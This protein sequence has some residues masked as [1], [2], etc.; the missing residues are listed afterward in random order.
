MEYPVSNNH[1][2]SRFECLMED[3]RS[4]YLDYNEIEEGLNFAH[5][6]VPKS[7]EGKG[8]AAALVKFGLEYAKSNG[9]L[10]QPSCPYVTAYIKRHPEYLS[11][12]K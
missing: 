2:A 11:L 5:T 10:I 4:A 1:E 9:M 6:Y 12:V 7:F 3:G 8:V